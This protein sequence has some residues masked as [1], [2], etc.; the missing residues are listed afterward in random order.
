M[1]LKAA[2]AA[3]AVALGALADAGPVLAQAASQRGFFDAAGIV[4]PQASPTGGDRWIGEALFR[5]E[6]AWRPASWLTLAGA[7][8][9]R[10]ATDD[11]VDASWNI[12]WSD[13]GR[14]RP[15]LSIRRAS[16][17]FV[18]RGLTVEAGKLFVRW[19]KADVLNPTDRFAPRDLLEVVDNEF[20]GITAVRATYEH[21]ADTLDVVWQPRFTPSRLPLP[22]GRWSASLSSRAPVASDSA[23]AGGG[24]AT[25]PAV[26]IPDQWPGRPQ[27]GVRWNHVGAGFEFSLS[28]FD[29][30]NHFPIFDVVPDPALAQ[31]EVTRVY[32]VMRM[33]GGDAAWPL[34]WFTLKGEIG[35]FWTTDSRVDDYGIYVVQMERQ[36]GDWLFVGGYAGEFVTNDRGLA[37][38]PAFAFDRA[39]TR[40]F[41]GRASYTIDATRS[42]AFEG[43]VRRDGSGGWV[44]AEYSQAFGQHWRTTL[45]GDVLGGEDLDFFG[46]YRRNSN[47]RLAVRYSY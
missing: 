4:Y 33:A 28:F 15:A 9:A 6:A 26:E 16:A 12:D 40:T 43:V 18:R 35:Y 19:G 13:R 14:Q 36:R 21:E 30:F 29:G 11:R 38:S 32:P 24:T 34:K 47:L 5:Q 3:C 41:L 2:A 31:A 22:G 23:A 10:A 20:L 39:L 8:D 1:N 37:A 25:L 42:L 27:S 7:F 44:K 45:R 17:A 46:R